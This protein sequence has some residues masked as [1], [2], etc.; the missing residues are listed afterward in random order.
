VRAQTRET[1]IHIFL[2]PTPEGGCDIRLEGKESLE[3][4]MKTVVNS[5]LIRGRVE[6]VFDL[7]T[8]ARFWPQWHPATL[9]VGGVRQR[10]FLL[11]DVI[12]ERA[13]LGPEVYEGDWTVAEHVRPSRAVLRAWGGRL[14]IRYVFAAAGEATEFRRE[15][16][17]DP[18]DFRATA[19]D[20]DALVK[21]M[22]EQSEQA[23]RKLKALVEDILDEEAKLEIGA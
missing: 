5:V 17:F 20:A 16:E 21:L 14:H 7:V 15:L 11:G 18:A 6:A 10:P 13:R 2:D 23:L 4:A 3:A 22:H 12:R 19:P 8:S 9:G 1:G